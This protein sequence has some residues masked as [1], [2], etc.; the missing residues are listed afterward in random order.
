MANNTSTSHGLG[1]LGTLQVIFI[2]LKVAG[3]TQIANW[4][5]IQVFIPTYINVAT[6][7]LAVTA[8]YLAKTKK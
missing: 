7:F 5:W 8:L 4:N 2:V 6:F 3:V 1:F